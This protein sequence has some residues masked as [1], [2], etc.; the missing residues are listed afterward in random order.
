[1]TSY[2]NSSDK[3]P[4]P[5][6]SE[7]IIKNTLYNTI[8]KFWG[9]LVVLF[10]TPYIVSRLGVERYGIWA[11]ITSLVGYIGFLDLGVGGS[12]ARYI[13]E[14]YTQKDYSKLNQVI[15]TGFLFCLGLAFILIPLALFFTEPLLM[16][17]KLDPSTYPEI[18]SVFFWGVVIFSLSNATFVFE[19]V[20]TGLQRMEITNIVAVVLTIPYALGFILFLELGYGLKGLMILIGIMWMIQ[21]LINFFIAKKILPQF[22]FNPFLFKKEMFS[23]LLR[24]GIKLQISRLSQLISFQVDKLLITYFLSVGMVTF[25]DLGAKITGSIRKLPLLLASA[26][27]PASAEI[28][29]KGD[30]ESLSKLYFRGSKYLFTVSA[31]LFFFIVVCSEMLV[32]VWMGPG[33][34]LASSVIRIL[35][36]G[37]FFNLIMRVASSVAL[38]MGKPEFEMKYGI[39]MSVL[40]FSLSLILIIKFGFYGVLVGTGFSLT[41]GSV[42][43]FHLFHSYIREPLINLWHWIKKPLGGAFLMAVI[44]FLFNSLTNATVLTNH[45]FTGLLFVGFEFVIFLTSYFLILMKLN[46]WDEYDKNLLRD[47]I[48]VARHVFKERHTT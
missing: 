10:L 34:D 31:P 15:N 8:G 32:N 9:I 17:L 42:Y 29:A 6:I 41:L 20:Q 19:S 3:E 44:L 28:F 30:K 43:F 22:S 38:G 39:L 45:R 7:K 24:F 33:Y 37:Y 14:Y 35:S 40:N 4:A 46:F 47:K 1:L 48:P 16:F 21:T 25:Y 23:E 18:K 27:V 13:A 26:L 11:L 12:F 36:V 5:R 2:L